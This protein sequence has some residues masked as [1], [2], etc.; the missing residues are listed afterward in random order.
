MQSGQLTFNGAMELIDDADSAEEIDELAESEGPS[1]S[2]AGAVHSNAK[3]RRPR[4]RTNT[5]RAPGH[6]LIPLPKVELIVHADC[7][8]T[9]LHVLLHAC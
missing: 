5:E 3:P 4:A 6:T 1:A 9:R 8:W 2:T 7:E